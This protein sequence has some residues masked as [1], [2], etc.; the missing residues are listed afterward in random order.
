[1]PLVK[2]MVA[3]GEVG[4]LSFPPQIWILVL[5]R[6]ENGVISLGRVD[7]LPQNIYNFPMTFL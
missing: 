2:S 7:S 4:G 5:N 1:M 6:K 3:L